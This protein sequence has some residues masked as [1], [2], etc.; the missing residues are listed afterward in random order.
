MKQLLFFNI[1]IL[2]LFSFLNSCSNPWMEDVWGIKI[3]SFDSDGGTKIPDQ[4]LLQREKIT[5]PANPAKANSTFEGWFDENGDVWNFDAIPARSLTLFA[6]W[7]SYRISISPVNFGIET[8]GYSPITPIPVTVTNTGNFE[9]GDLTITL[10]GANAGSFNMDLTGLPD[11]LNLDVGDFDTF[12]VSVNDGLAAGTYTAVITVTNGSTITATANVSFTVMG[13]GSAVSG[14]PVIEVNASSSTPSTITVTNA[15]SLS[16][17]T[18]TGQT[19]EYAISTANNITNGND[20][21]TWQDSNVFT[22]LTAGTT[23]YV[24]AR[25]KANSV[26]LTGAISPASNG[27]LFNTAGILININPIGYDITLTPS[28]TINISRTSNP[29]I[30]LTIGNFTDFNGGVQWIYNGVVL[31]TGASYTIN[32]ASPEY[33]LDGTKFLTI[34][35]VKDGVP[36]NVT[37]TFTVAD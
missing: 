5:R 23:Y 28:G 14:I 22:G 17:V 16:L 11:P 3:I 31:A 33:N 37:L 19:I 12:T 21:N 30:Q 24:Y 29:S 18:A 7:S 13:V 26:Y 35:V 2:L 9:T 10:T 20:L 6:K 1:I 34:R 32:A 8:V 27:V 36:E 4:K 25:S 15:S